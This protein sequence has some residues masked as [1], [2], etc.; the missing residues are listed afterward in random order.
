MSLLFEES[1]RVYNFKGWDTECEGLVSTSTTV[2]RLLSMMQ[3]SCP[4]MTIT[5]TPICFV[6]KGT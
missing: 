1:L 5:W 3:V 2:L 4:S 6:F